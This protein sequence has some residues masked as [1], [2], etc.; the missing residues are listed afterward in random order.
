MGHEPAA[1][2]T[3]HLAILLEIPTP[4]AVD[5]RAEDFET[6]FA[7]WDEAFDVAFDSA[8]R[9]LRDRIAVA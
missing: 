9:R 8:Q 7:R 5:A 2:P 6:P 1:L 3:S 4:V